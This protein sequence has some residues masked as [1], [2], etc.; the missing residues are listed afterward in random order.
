MT[1]T[2]AL[3]A[4]TL[5]PFGLFNFWPVFFNK[6]TPLP[7]PEPKIVLTTS[8]QPVYDIIFEV[9]SPTP[10]LS[11]LEPTVTV[12]PSVTPHPSVTKTPTPT[13][14]KT[15]SIIAAALP[16]AKPTKAPK[17]TFSPTPQP[18]SAPSVAGSSVR[19]YIMQEIND[20]RRSQGLSEVKTDPY[21]C[22]FAS[23]RASEITSGFNHDGFSN[24]LNSKTMPYPGYIVVTENL[25]K[26]SD[27]K[28]VA[29]LWIASS[30][31]AANMR[32]D[33]P[34]VCVENNGIYYAY[35]GWKP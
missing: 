22:G 19:D 12:T 23:T 4:T 29:S 8:S 30:G 2:S 32:K 9:I 27:Y 1:L 35:E 6:P 10:T 25:A 26:A 17:P 14:T 18:I 13:P 31:H 15:P 3:L 33:T 24:R 20:Y 34:F 5:V 21:S 16:T 28:K 7:P 11:E